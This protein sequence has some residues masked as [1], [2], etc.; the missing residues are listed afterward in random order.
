[1]MHASLQAGTLNTPEKVAELHS[2]PLILSE[3][4]C[5]ARKLSPLTQVYTLTFK[6]A[7][8]LMAY[9]K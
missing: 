5:G 8:L 2:V 1:M 3:E 7:Q 4:G 6:T 9:S